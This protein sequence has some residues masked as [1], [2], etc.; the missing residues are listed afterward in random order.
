MQDWR[1]VLNPVEWGGRACELRRCVW[2]EARGRLSVCTW[3]QSCLRGQR[4]QGLQRTSVILTVWGATLQCVE[5]HPEATLKIR[6]AVRKS[7]KA[8]RVVVG[9]QLLGEVCWALHACTTVEPSTAPTGSLLGGFPRHVQT[10]CLTPPCRHLS[11]QTTRAPGEREG[12]ET[13]ALL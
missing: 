11:R 3:L 6:C 2:G 4:F 5:G 1:A 10:G 8:G 13:R 12:R 9:Q 7:S